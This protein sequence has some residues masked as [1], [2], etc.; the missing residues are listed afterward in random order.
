MHRIKAFQLGGW[1]VSHGY[2]FMTF[3]SELQTVQLILRVVLKWYLFPWEM[4]A[5]WRHFPS[6]ICSPP[7]REHTATALHKR[8]IQLIF[9]HQ[10]YQWPFILQAYHMIHMGMGER[11]PPNHIMGIHCWGVSVKRGST[12]SLN[13]SIVH[14]CNYIVTN[15]WSQQHNLFLSVKGSNSW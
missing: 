6:N 14:W 9:L 3:H 5:P 1:I 15:F 2:Y 12:I 4:C 13:I 7:R 8:S 11:Q 10:I